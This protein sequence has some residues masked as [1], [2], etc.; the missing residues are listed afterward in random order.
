MSIRE[1]ALPDL[2]EG[3]TDS[4]LVSWEVAVG[5][6]VELNQIIAEVETAKALVQLPSP[7]AGVVTSLLAEPGETVAVGQSLLAFEVVD[8]EVVDAEAPAAAVPAPQLEASP[9]SGVPER[10]SVLVGYGPRVET[11][12]HPRRRARRPAPAP[13]PAVAEGDDAG[14]AR[15]EPPEPTA[16]P[17]PPAVGERRVAISAVRRRTAEAMV[18]SAFGAPQATVFLTIDASPTLELIERLSR[19]AEFE[20][21]RLGLLAVVAKAVLLSLA[22]A[23]A[24]NA[25]WDGEAGEIIE[26]DEVAL[27]I[28]AATPRGLLVPNIRAANRLALPQLV[29]ALSDLTSKARAATT[30]PEEL[31]GGTFTITNI[32]VFG[33]DAGTPILMPGEA[34]ILALGALRRAPWE[35]QGEVAL[36]SVLSLSLSFDHR[37]VDGAQASEFLMDVAAILRDPGSALAM[38]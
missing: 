26:F 19:G 23:P 29:D 3:L 17:A 15:P 7:W 33:M 32:G 2:G 27:G 21:R 8:A 1:F 12:E 14:A 22:R 20:G 30:A 25:R 34:G 10:T 4:E 11:G 9:A 24:L 13:D 28:A 37:V 18:A 5:D 36:R 6:S 35:H 31:R 38:V 16:P